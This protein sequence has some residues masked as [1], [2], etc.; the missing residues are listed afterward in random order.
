MTRFLWLC[1]AALTPVFGTIQVRAVTTAAG[2]A[3][4]LPLPGSLG[5]IFCTGLVGTTGVRVV[6]PTG[7]A[8]IL[9][10]ADLGSQ[11]QVNFQ[12]PWEARGAATLVQGNERAELPRE[13]AA[14]GQFF[15]GEDGFVVGQHAA[16]YALVT[17]ANPARPGEWILIYG[18][19]F[20]PFDPLWKWTILLRTSDKVFEL[21]TN[22]MGLALGAPGVYQFNVKMPDEAPKGEARVAIEGSRFCGFFLVAGCGRGLLLRNSATIRLRFE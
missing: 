12:V 16:D 10:V 17:A 3:P 6:F 8:P 14:W 22:Y 19:N 4:G 1:L 20:S 2:F 21:T 5:S 13:L 9:A 15:S 7:D 11:Q 18:T